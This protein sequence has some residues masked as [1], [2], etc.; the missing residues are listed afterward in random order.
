MIRYNSFNIN[1]ISDEEHATLTHQT[2]SYLLL[3]GIQFLLY[4]HQLCLIRRI[5]NYKKLLHRV[6]LAK[7]PKLHKKFLRGDLQENIIKLSTLE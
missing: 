1:A 5:Y 3:V 7:V 6:S 2:H 4:V